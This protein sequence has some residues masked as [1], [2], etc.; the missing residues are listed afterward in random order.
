[1]TVTNY[2]FCF[3]VLVT[4]MPVWLSVVSCADG[5]RDVC[6]KFLR[7]LSMAVVHYDNKDTR[8]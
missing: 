2:P 6:R 1:M 7:E 8:L 4:Q 3:S 5:R